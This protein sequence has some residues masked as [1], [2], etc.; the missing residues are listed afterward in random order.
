MV[1][2]DESIASNWTLMYLHDFFTNANDQ[3]LKIKKK[4]CKFKKFQRSRKSTK[5]ISQKV[6]KKF[7]NEM[8]NFAWKRFRKVL[9]SLEKFWIDQEKK[10]TSEK[11]LKKL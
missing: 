3:D 6:F 4:S 9:K 2:Y 11:V 5:W 7:W 1:F 8:K 10:W